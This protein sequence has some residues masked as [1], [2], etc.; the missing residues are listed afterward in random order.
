MRSYLYQ[1]VPLSVLGAEPIAALLVARGTDS[2]YERSFAAVASAD[3]LNFLPAP[4]FAAFGL[5]YVVVTTTL[6]GA[7]AVLLVSLLALSVLL[8]AG[9]YVGWRYREALAARLLRGVAAVERRLADRLPLVRVPPPDVVARRVEEG[10]ATLERIAADRRTLVLG[11]GT[12]T[13]GWLLFST[14]LWLALLAVGYGV[15][16]EVPLFI[17]PLVSVTD[18]FPLPG[19]AG[20]VDATLVL[21][22]VGVTGVPAPA[23]TAGVLVHRAATFLFAIVVGGTAVAVVQWS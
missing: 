10:L 17:V 16:V 20:A 12:S 8:L 11:L 18:L 21:L 23:A 1:V 15:P 13:L 7:L 19:G 5:L 14:V 22:V 2:S 3:L 4:A 6:G 9:G